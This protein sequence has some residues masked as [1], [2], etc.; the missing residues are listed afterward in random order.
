MKTKLFL[1][2]FIALINFNCMGGWVSQPLN[3]L[4]AA[5]TAPAGFTLGNVVYFGTGQ[6]NTGGILKDFWKLEN[7]VWT[8]LAEFGDTTIAHTGG[9]RRYGAVGF[10]LGNKGYIGSGRDLGGYYTDFYQYD[11]LANR[12]TLSSPMPGPGRMYAVAF[13]ISG[14]AYVGTGRDVSNNRNDFYEFDTISG[15]TVKDSFP[16]AVTEAAGFSIGLKGYI[17]TGYSTTYTNSFYEYDPVSDVWTAKASFPGTARRGASGFSIGSSGYI[18][19]GYDGV[20]KTDFWEW[21]NNSWSQIT[22]IPNGTRNG[23]GLSTCSRGYVG[24]GN[25]NT[26]AM[27]AYIPTNSPTAGFSSKTNLCLG[28]CINFTDTSTNAPTSWNWDF[29]NG[30]VSIV[31]H[32]TNICFT[33]AGVDT[34]T[35]TTMSNGNCPSTVTHVITVN[36]PNDNDP[37][38]IDACDTATGIVSN[39]P[40]NTN[41]NNACTIDACNSVTGTIT[42]TA[43]NSDDSNACTIDGCDSITGIFHNAININDTNACTIDACD[44]ITGNITHTF[45]NISDNDICTI[46]FCDTINGAITHTPTPVV[47]I[48]NDTTMQAGTFILD[49]GSGFSSYIWSNGDTTQSIQDSLGGIYSVTVTDSNGCTS[50]AS[51]EI[52]FTGFDNI[53]DP[54]ITISPNPSNGK[55]YISFDEDVIKCRI[56]ILNS[57]GQIVYHENNRSIKKGFLKMIELKEKAGIYY[58]RLELDKRIILKKLVFN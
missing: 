16:I 29:S 9:L 35:L 14:K 49:A 5:R 53:F 7:N 47:N 58:L 57:L 22:P 1:T 21:H 36:D 3:S 33:Q 42:H 40:V 37:C 45:V 12:W 50:S 31:Q 6:T 41:D 28:A 10:A 4:A 51:I 26:T 18:G 54:L 48:G 44:I 38:T 17:G 25:Y 11:T 56:E 23:L 19:T 30:N 24:F 34:V 27:L 39:T 32:P 20:I 8:Q 55:F 2:A 13:T 15:W 46:D 52:I 43:I